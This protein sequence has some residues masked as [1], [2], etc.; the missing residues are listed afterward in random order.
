MIYDIFEKMFYLQFILNVQFISRY[1]NLKIN[2]N[3]ILAMNF[4][5]EFFS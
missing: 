5:L 2:S 3:I 1:K 4:K